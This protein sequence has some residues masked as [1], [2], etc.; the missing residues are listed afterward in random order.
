MKKLNFSNTVSLSTQFVILAC[1]V[2]TFVVMIGSGMFLLWEKR[3]M[4]QE[5]EAKGKTISFFVAQLSMDPF[6]YKDALKLNNIAG[7]AIKEKEVVY[8]FFLD[9]GNKPVTS[10]MGSVNLEN[11]LTK[12][13]IHPGEDPALALGMLQKNKD[14][15][16]IKTPVTDGSSVIGSLVLGMSKADMHKRFFMLVIYNWL[17]GIGIILCLSASIF[18]MFR[19]AAVRPIQLIISK[20]E[21]IAAGDLRDTDDIGGSREMMALSKAIDTIAYSLKNV[22]FKVMSITDTLS[23]VTSTIAGSSQKVLVRAEAQKNEIIK[24]AAA[25]TDMNISTARLAATSESLSTLSGQTSAAITQLN[26]SIHE[27]AE[28]A[29][30]FNE[31]SHETAASVEEMIS[32]IKN[33]AENLNNVSASS[34]ETSAALS[35]MTVSVKEVEKNADKSVVLAEKVSAEASSSGINAINVALQ[36]MTEIK[37]TMNS[38]S[39][40]IHRLLERSKSIGQILNVIDDVADQTTLISLNAAILASK[41]GTYG[42]GFSVVADAIKE[43]AERTAVS[44]TEISNLITSVQA[45][46]KASVE[47]TARGLQAVEK[48]IVLFNDVKGGLTDIINNS[49]SSTE[50]ARMIRKSSSEEALAINQITESTNIILEHI[51]RIAGA[52]DEQTKGN[53]FILESNEKM[54][55]VSQ[56]IQ[57]ST[58]E[59]SQGSRQITETMEKVNEQAVQIAEAT[60][61]QRD[62]SAVIAET[63]EK[64]KK[65]TDEL[66]GS[67]VEMDGQIAGLKNEATNLVSELQKFKI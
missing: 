57:T 29:T 50:M 37:E 8:A 31:T 9:T 7:A 59:Q 15:L 11:A 58:K 66:I 27:I 64:I 3:N 40:V 23:V 10:L 24:T 33:I 6:L 60:N 32:S 44:T 4:M 35:E 30:M 19:Y 36:G 52:T 2:V 55:D 28:N 61:N 54:K 41:A 21:K 25:I 20:T 42:K 13:T 22:I 51:N 45:E 17:F 56:L 62:R 1:V 47:M 18:I 16:S 63:M 48:G 39:E 67:S 34:S 12:D 49:R 26:T 5:L 43:L 38:I 46:T 14:I 65:A 53:R